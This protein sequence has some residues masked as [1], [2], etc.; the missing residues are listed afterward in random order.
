MRLRVESVALG[1]PTHAPWLAR[2][3]LVHR[4]TRMTS[5]APVRTGGAVGAGWDLD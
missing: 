3:S 5:Q 1:V 4:E 2:R